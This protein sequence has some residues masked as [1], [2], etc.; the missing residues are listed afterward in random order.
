MRIESEK[1]ISNININ[2]L[3][4]ENESLK[5]ELR[6]SK[7]EIINLKSII[8]RGKNFEK[9]LAEKNRVINDLENKLNIKSTNYEKMIDNLKSQIKFNEKEIMSLK[10][11]SGDDLILPLFEGET[12]MSILIKSIDQ[13]VLFTVPC[14]NTTPFHKIELKFFK[15][16]PEYKSDA[17]F[18]LNGGGKIDRY[19]TVEENKIENGIPI[20][21]NN[22]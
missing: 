20:L 9:E 7:E 21:M 8:E 19:L 18:F 13:R 14:K 10:N 15:K 17:T 3:L 1:S 6:I 11:S 12:I 22:Q 5:N 16:Y 4:E 2:E